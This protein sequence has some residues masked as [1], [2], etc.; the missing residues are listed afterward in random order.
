MAPVAAATA[1]PQDQWIQATFASSGC[2]EGDRFFTPH[3]VRMMAVLAVVV[4]VSALPS[5]S[6]CYAPAAVPAT[7]NGRSSCYQA[8]KSVPVTAILVP[9][10][11]RTAQVLLVAWK[12]CANLSQ[13]SRR[14]AFFGKGISP[15]PEV[16][17]ANRRFHH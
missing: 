6:S 8:R 15:F 12:S 13:L 11:T 17:G 1:S 14:A 3:L 9:V 7:G 2:F 10:T 16:S 4:L 5:K